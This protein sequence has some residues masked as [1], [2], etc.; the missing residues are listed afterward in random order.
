MADDRT[1]NMIAMGVAETL[2]PAFVCFGCLALSWLLV[3]L[4]MRRTEHA[5]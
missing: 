4:G 5:V 1:F 2:I 3:A